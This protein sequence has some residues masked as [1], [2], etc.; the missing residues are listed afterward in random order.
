[1]G[2]CAGKNDSMTLCVTNISNFYSLLKTYLLNMLMIVDGVR[3]AIN[4]KEDCVKICLPEVE[5]VQEPFN[6]ELYSTFS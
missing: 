3:C 2:L 5:G 4:S 6:N 1:M